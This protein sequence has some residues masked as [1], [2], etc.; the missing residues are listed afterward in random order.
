MLLGEH[1]GVLMLVMFLL[2]CIY[3]LIHLSHNQRER[4]RE[5]ER[6]NI[7]KRIF[8]HLYN[9]TDSKIEI[10]QAVPFG[11]SCIQSLYWCIMQRIF[12]SKNILSNNKK[13]SVEISK[14]PNQKIH[15]I[16]INN[17]IQSLILCLNTALISVDNYLAG[18]KL[19]IA[20]F[21]NQLR[22]L[23]TK[24]KNAKAKYWKQ[25]RKIF[26]STWIPFYFNEIS[27][28]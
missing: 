3:H 26:F 18:S 8:W 24:F 6:K 10:P 1:L 23:L 22:N 21:G 9:W 5:R 7:Q 28:N 2:Y 13:G 19:R 14:H 17:V 27:L 4:E 25:N 16:G 11:Y 20:F 12:S 15:S